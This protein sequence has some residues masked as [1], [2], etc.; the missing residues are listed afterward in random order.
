[1][2]NKPEWSYPRHKYDVD[3]PL[4]NTRERLEYLLSFFR[5]MA[6]KATGFRYKDWVDFKSC[7]E[8]NT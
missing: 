7:A 2:T 3:F 1:M 5:A 6:G 8:R 4:A